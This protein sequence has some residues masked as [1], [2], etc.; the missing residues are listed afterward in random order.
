MEDPRSFTSLATRRRWE[1]SNP[2]FERLCYPFWA[3]Q[4]IVIHRESGKRRPSCRTFFFLFFLKRILTCISG[5][6]YLWVMECVESR[7]S[8]KTPSLS[9][10]CSPMGGHQ[11]FLKPFNPENGISAAS[12]IWPIREHVCRFFLRS[13]LNPCPNRIIVKRAIDDTGELRRLSLTLKGNTVRVFHAEAIGMK[14]IFGILRLFWS[15]WK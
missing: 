7:M 8:K 12:G 15:R 4:D 10:K 6:L 14:L 11:F 2:D 13:G 9:P 3:W 1:V 5:K